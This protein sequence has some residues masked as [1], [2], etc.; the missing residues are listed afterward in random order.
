MSK[1][2]IFKLTDD[3]HWEYDRM[4]TSGQQTMDKLSELLTEYSHELLYHEKVK[5][6]LWEYISKNDEEEIFKRIG[7]EAND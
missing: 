1:K 3:L 5:E 2:E 4:S 6:I 7:E